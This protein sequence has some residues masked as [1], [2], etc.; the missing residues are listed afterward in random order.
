MQG[1]GRPPP[2]ADSDWHHADWRPNK[3]PFTVTP[4]PRNAAAELDS[5]A[6]LVKTN[7]SDE[8]RESVF[9]FGQL[10]K[11]SQY[12]VIVTKKLFWKRGKERDNNRWGS[13]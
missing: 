8:S 13:G 2:V 10:R 1:G 9:S 5:D 3:I 6:F 12:I 4:G 7:E 11:V